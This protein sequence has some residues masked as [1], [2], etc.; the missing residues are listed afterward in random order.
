MGQFKITH[1]IT[2]IPSSITHNLLKNT[3]EPRFFF[4]AWLKHDGT[5]WTPEKWLPPPK[6]LGSLTWSSYLWIVRLWPAAW[7]QKSEIQNMVDS[8]KFRNLN[9]R[10]VSLMV[11][12]Y[13]NGLRTIC[14]FFLHHIIIQ[15]YSA[16]LLKGIRHWASLGS[17]WS[18]LL[19][20]RLVLSFIPER[21]SLKLVW[22]E[23]VR[24]NSTEESFRIVR[25]FI[26][27]VNNNYSLTWI[28]AIWGWFPLL[29]MISSE[30]VV[31]S[32]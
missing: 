23:I 15:R 29:T 31:S 28:K 2:N 6:K 10:L 17:L 32:L 30:L 8:W 11:D 18:L 21:S 1:T 12:E 14:F 24:K 19:W 20:I 9:V 7:N 27:W 16:S 13:P 4:Y 26:V 22:S 5:W 3:I 25:W